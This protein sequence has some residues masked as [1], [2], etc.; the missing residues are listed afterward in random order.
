M[1]KNVK[2]CLR[3]FVK[4]HKRKNIF[5]RGTGFSFA[6]SWFLKLELRSQTECETWELSHESDTKA[7]W[8]PYRPSKSAP[9]DAL[10]GSFGV[11]P[12]ACTCLKYVYIVYKFWK[13]RLNCASYTWWLSLLSSGL[14]SWCF[15]RRLTEQ[16][17]VLQNL[18]EAATNS[19]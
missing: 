8:A 10:L 17:K 16:T 13:K 18:T 7:R 9:S 15:L 14:S 1:F 4:K 2:L 19:V 12:Y 11:L 5:T 6:I 3:I